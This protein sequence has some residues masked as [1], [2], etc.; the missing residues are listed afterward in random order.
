MRNA[1]DQRKT[2]AYV[3]TG[4]SDEVQD[5][6]QNRPLVGVVCESGSK[7]LENGRLRL[8]IHLT[9]QQ[10]ADQ[11]E[12][13][14]CSNRFTWPWASHDE[15]RPSRRSRSE[16]R[17]DRTKSSAHFQSRSGLLKF[18]GAAVVPMVKQPQV[19]S[20]ISKRKSPFGSRS[21]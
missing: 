8:C 20:M 17:V 18:Q 13:D 2:A 15:R 9:A 19:G 7:L 1:G 16:T 21:S 5:L 3:I 4:H 10:C 12:G 14:T 11:Y 6:L